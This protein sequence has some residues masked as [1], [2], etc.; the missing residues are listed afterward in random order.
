MNPGS[1][2]NRKSKA[3]RCGC[4]YPSRSHAQSSALLTYELPSTQRIMPS[5]TALDTLSGLAFWTTSLCCS[6]TSSLYI[7]EGDTVQGLAPLPGFIQTPSTGWWLSQAY[8]HSWPFSWSLAGRFQRSEIS[9]YRCALEF[10]KISDFINV[11]AYAVYYRTSPQQ[12]LGQ[13][14]IF[15]CTNMS[16]VKHSHSHQISINNL[17]SIKSSLLL[18]EK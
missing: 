6:P 1:K 9:W 5:R 3:A 11:Y 15:K 13:H 8:F 14:P 4:H 17:I 2:M 12:D 7:V 10:Y 18:N 16:A